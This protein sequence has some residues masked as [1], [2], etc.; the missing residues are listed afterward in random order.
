MQDGIVELTKVVRSL[1]LSTMGESGLTVG[2]SDLEAEIAI[3]K[4]LEVGQ[5]AHN[6][7]G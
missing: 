4:I 7:K 3:E 2:Q 5:F 6:F 1:L